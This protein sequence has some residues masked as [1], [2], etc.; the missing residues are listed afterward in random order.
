MVFNIFMWLPAI[1]SQNSL[2]VFSAGSSVST[3][4][5]GSSGPTFL[6]E[7]EDGMGAIELESG[8]GAIELESGP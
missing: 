5:G 7:L 2:A 6:I 8:A 1:D 4:A 3:R